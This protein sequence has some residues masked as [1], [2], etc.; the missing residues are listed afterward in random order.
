[1]PT[2]LFVPRCMACREQAAVIDEG[3][4]FCGSCFLDRTLRQHHEKRE[5]ERKSESEPQRQQKR[6]S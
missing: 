1:M 2:F 5:R 3:K 4:Y 6:A